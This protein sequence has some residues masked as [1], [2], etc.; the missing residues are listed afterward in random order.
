M[1]QAVLLCL[2][3]TIIMISFLMLMQTRLINLVKLLI[4]QNITLTI[5]ISC[6]AIFF[7]SLALYLSLLIT[8]IIKVIILPWLLWKVVI[9]LKITYN[10]DPIM[11]KS[12]LQ[13]I[14]IVVVVFALL[15][16]HQI[17]GAIGRQDI[18]GFSLALANSLLSLLLIIFRR[19]VISEMIGLLVLEN[20]IFLLSATLTSGFPWLVEL[21]MD[22]DILIAFM[23]FSLFILRI[24]STHG[25]L[26]IQNV[27]RS[28]EKV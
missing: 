15:L 28:K 20:S 1:I 16:S 13:M 21:G 7:P 4:L 5:Y 11:R 17:E 25:S 10:V 19:K 6:K 18:V 24:R 22:F 14:G 9:Y 26:Q 27:E 23:I 3:S 2:I 12:T 8:F